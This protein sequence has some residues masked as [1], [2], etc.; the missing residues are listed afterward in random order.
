MKQIINRYKSLL[1]ILCITLCGSILI[2]HVNITVLAKESRYVE[3]SSLRKNS[4]SEKKESKIKNSMG[5]MT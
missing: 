2:S 3:N 1:K 4:A 5:H